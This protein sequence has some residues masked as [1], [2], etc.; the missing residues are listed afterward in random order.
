[1][2][3]TSSRDWER[4]I[5]GTGASGTEELS[6]STAGPLGHSR[7]RVAASELLRLPPDAEKERWLRYQRSGKSMRDVESNTEQ[8][9]E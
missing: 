1:M 4:L 3:G 7:R 8:S 6:G 5:L 2:S 9:Y